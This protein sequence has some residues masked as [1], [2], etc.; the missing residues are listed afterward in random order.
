MRC[1]K[2]HPCGVE[3]TDWLTQNLKPEPLLMTFEKS[4]IP[5]TRE[6][7]AVGK[8]CL[9]INANRFVINVQQAHTGVCL[10]STYFWLCGVPFLRR[11][12]KKS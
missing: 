7:E 9:P 4:Q 1:T 11:L 3:E 8:D 5:S 12:S 10:L 6:G 2:Q